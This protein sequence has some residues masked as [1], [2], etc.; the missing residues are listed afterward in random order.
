MSA[1]IPRALLRSASR[2]T[3]P[4]SLSG[5][6]LVVD[7][8][9]AIDHGDDL[10]D[11]DSVQFLKLFGGEEGQASLSL[12]ITLTAT[13]TDNDG[14]QASSSST[15]VIADNDPSSQTSIVSFQDDG[16]AF[17][18]TAHDF[19]QNS[20]FFDGFVENNDRGA[21]AAASYVRNAGGWTIADQ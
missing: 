14:D 6:Q 8:Y 5:A 1:T 13:I 20:F 4:D 15:I 21:R 3:D 10:N 17:T 7:Q 19:A 2:L 16:P 11:F 18:V 9:M 12:G